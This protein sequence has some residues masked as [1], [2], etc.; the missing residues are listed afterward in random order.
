VK[1]PEKGSYTAKC[2]PDQFRTRHAIIPFSP[3]AL[4]EQKFTEHLLAERRDVV[5]R[6]M[7]RLE[8]TVEIRCWNQ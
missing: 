3:G 5:N 4:P 6:V 1:A 2:K 8:Q 7:K